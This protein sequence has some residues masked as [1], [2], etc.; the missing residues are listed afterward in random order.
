MCLSENVSQ[1]M[2]LMPSSCFTVSELCDIKQSFQPLYSCLYLY[3]NLGMILSF[4]QHSQSVVVEATVLYK[5]KPHSF[6]SMVLKHGCTLE[7]PG[8]LK[9]F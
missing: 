2:V 6:K 1:Y 8:L 5:L 4:L 3:I 9:N 7:S